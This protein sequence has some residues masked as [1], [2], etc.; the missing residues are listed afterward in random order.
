MKNM[1]SL[2]EWKNVAMLG[3][4]VFT[5]L[6]VGLYIIL[7]IAARIKNKTQKRTRK[8]IIHK[9]V[10]IDLYDYLTSKMKQEFIGQKKVVFNEL[11]K[12]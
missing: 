10:K 8:Q 7:E 4:I 5:T 9:A 6:I 1:M 11:I 12:M 2:Q 3:F